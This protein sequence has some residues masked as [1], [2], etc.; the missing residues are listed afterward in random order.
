METLL[1]ALKLHK[2][3]HKFI[4]LYSMQ[5]CNYGLHVYAKFLGLQPHVFMQ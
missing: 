2:T 5:I 3:S 1:I 4:Q